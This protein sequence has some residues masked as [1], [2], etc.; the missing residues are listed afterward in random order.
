MNKFIKALIYFLLI[1]GI[2]LLV[3]PVRWFPSFYDVR[4]MG[5]MALAGS[6]II[7]FL[8][9]LI[10]AP[11]KAA[12]T[13]KKNRVALW[14]QYFL[15]FTFAANAF[16]DLGLYKLYQYGFEFDKALH[17]LISLLAVIILPFVLGE[18]WKIR[19]AYAVLISFFTVV[20]FGVGWE[21]YEYL[22]DL[23]LK[24]HI[25]GVY[26]LDISADTK[27]DLLF[28]FL[29]SATGVISWVYLRKFFAEREKAR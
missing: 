21:V 7:F 9:G 12:E 5:W 24:T 3:F 25:S 29:G 16:G 2:I 4:Y 18:R 14:L 17:F 28:D 11:K 6:A 8:P 22:A 1:G 20:V 15:A 10:F 13:S 26:G 23:L 19:P 27:A